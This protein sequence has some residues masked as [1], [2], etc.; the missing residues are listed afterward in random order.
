MKDR[1]V[2]VTCTDDGRD[3]LVADEA[4]AAGNAGAGRFWAL[5]GHRVWPALLICPPGPPC[6]GCVAVARAYANAPSSRDRRQRRSGAR[7]RPGVVSRLRR[8]AR[9]QGHG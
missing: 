5:C 2:S 8:A 4:M 1:T 6:P 7:G 3:H 9:N